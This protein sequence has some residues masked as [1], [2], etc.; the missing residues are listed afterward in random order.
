M[1]KKQLVPRPVENYHRDV[2]C[3]KKGISFSPWV[4]SIWHFITTL[5]SFIILCPHLPVLSLSGSKIIPIF[6]W[7][8]MG[9]D[10]VLIWL[11]YMLGAWKIEPRHKL[12]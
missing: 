8:Q 10:I 12:D 5:L 4:L 1:N 6:S 9:K 11:R 2:Y 7:L 3:D